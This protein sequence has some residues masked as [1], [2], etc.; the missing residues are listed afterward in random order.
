[1]FK[2]SEEQGMPEGHSAVTLVLRVVL[3]FW[4]S[5]HVTVEMR[6]V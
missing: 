5:S 3:L 6:P 2:L 4:K 1:M